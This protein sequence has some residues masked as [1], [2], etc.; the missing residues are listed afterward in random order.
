M[1]KITCIL[2]LMV[3]ISLVAMAQ[4]SGANPKAEG[5]LKA[6]MATIDAMDKMLAKDYTMFTSAEKAVSGSTFTF[7]DCLVL[8]SYG[9]EAINKQ[10]KETEKG[11]AATFKGSTW[12]F[13]SYNQYTQTILT[14][15]ALNGQSERTGY[16]AFPG[17]AT[18]NMG[19]T[20]IQGIT[21]EAYFYQKKDDTK[22][23]IMVFGL[24]NGVA[25]Y[26][27]IEKK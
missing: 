26:A 9:D 6:N 25:C 15:T 18:V 12:K 4:P 5:Q 11:L 2:T 23:F 21:L 3:G 16:S 24:M 10:M 13:D 1:K 17:S 14:V 7:K 8:T 20:I 19:S 27:E 22:S